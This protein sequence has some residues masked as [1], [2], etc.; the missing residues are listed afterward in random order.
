MQPSQA[1]QAELT[2]TLQEALD[3]ASRDLKK[4]IAGLPFIIRNSS[5]LLGVAVDVDSE[6]QCDNIL[7]YLKPIYKG[8]KIY[9]AP[10]I[11]ISIMWVLLAETEA[12]RT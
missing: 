4:W 6:G 11:T 2:R 9:L 1:G 7:E 5:H 8:Y 12:G 10:S 3:A